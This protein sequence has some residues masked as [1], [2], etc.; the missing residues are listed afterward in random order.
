MKKVFAIVAIPASGPPIVEVGDSLSPLIDRAKAAR[1]S[2][3]FGKE[4][5]AEVHVLSSQNFGA[6]RYRCNPAPVK[7][8]RA[9]KAE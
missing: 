4:P 8:A 2:G 7:K 5:C 9:K 6:L 3:L 1:A